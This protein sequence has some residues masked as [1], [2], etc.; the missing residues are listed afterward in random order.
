MGNR[1]KQ[2]NR[3]LGI[4]FHAVADIL[5]AYETGR[6]AWHSEAIDDHSFFSKVLPLTALKGQL[7][8]CK[9]VYTGSQ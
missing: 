7:L 5:L 6:D 3:L 9:R 8:A 4:A 1:L 2:S